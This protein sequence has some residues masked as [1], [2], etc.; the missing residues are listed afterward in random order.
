MVIQHVTF[1]AQQSFYGP[2]FLWAKKVTYRESEVLI[3]VVIF[4]IVESF[5]LA[6]NCIIGRGERQHYSKVLNLLSP[7]NLVNHL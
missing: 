2:R 5:L 4:E 3:W 1:F 7:M 6:M